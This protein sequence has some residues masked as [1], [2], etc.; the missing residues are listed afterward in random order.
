MK[1]LF[2]FIALLFFLFS[3]NS[4]NAHCPLCTAAIGVTAIGAS[5]LGVNKIVIG[6]FVGALAMSMG[7][8]FSRIIKKKYIPFQKFIIVT[9]IFLLTVLPLSSITKSI[10]PFY[11]SIF[12]DYGSLLNRTY[13][14]DLSLIAGIIGG[15]IVYISPAISKKIKELRNGKGISYQTIAINI[16]LLAII[17]IIIQVSIT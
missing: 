11:I 12:G 2:L 5:W 1:I 14:I 16:I 9:G 3:A 8:W 6:L 17:A 13:I 7:M 10:Y 15:I 4:V